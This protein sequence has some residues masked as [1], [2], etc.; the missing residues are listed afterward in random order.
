MQGN[1]E[2]IPL[3]YELGKTLGSATSVDELVQFLTDALVKSLGCDNS[4]VWLL[5]R[6][7]GT[8]TCGSAT[9]PSKKELEGMEARLGEGLIGELMQ[10]QRELWL[11][12]DDDPEKII[13]RFSREFREKTRFMAFV[14]L[15]GREELLGAILLSHRS[16]FREDKRMRNMTFLK[17]LAVD[18]ASAMEDAHNREQL[19]KRIRDLST[20]S[21]VGTE[22]NTSLELDKVLRSVVLNIMGHFIVEKVAILLLDD[23]RERLGPVESRGLPDEISNLDFSCEGELAQILMGTQRPV[24]CYELEDDAVSLEEREKLEELNAFVLLPVLC[25]DEFLGLITVGQKVTGEAYDE[26]DVEFLSTIAKQTGIAAKNCMLF[27]AER[28]AAELSLLLEISKEITSTLDIDRVLHAFVNLSSQVIN[29]DRAAVALLRGENLA[30]SALSGQEK[31]DR[32]AQEVSALEE[33][34]SWMSGQG[35]SIY[36]TSLEGQIQAQNQ[37]TKDRLKEYFEKSQM[38]S[39]LAVPLVDEEGALGVLSME[40]ESQS[41][42]TESNLEVIEI[43][44]NQ[45]TVA[46]RNAELYGKIPL[47]KVIHP[48]V[49]KKR[50]FFKI[51]RRKLGTIIAGATIILALLLLW[52]SELKITCPME[53]WPQRT[54]TIAA[55]VEGILQEV[56][57]RDGHVVQTG[58][59]LA[60]LHNDHISSRLNQVKVWLATSRGNARNLFAANRISQYQTEQDEIKKLEA[61]LTFLETQVQ[62][63]EMASPISGTILTPLLEEK[64]GEYLE[65]GD[66]FC[67]VALLDSM[68]AEI[69]FPAADIHLAEENQEIKLLLSAFPEKTFW[70]TVEKVS[71]SA[72]FGQD[73]NTFLVKGRIDNAD[74]LLKPGMTGHARV[75]CGKRSLAY[76]VFRKPGRLVRELAWRLFGL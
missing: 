59:Q 63:T 23:T 36:V 24:F 39:F 58:Q 19:A 68:R 76:V 28:K 54:Y 52:R 38:K 9:A 10:D 30:L 29:Y 35:Q 17:R 57:V 32:K 7:Q 61:E 25:Q 50:A 65:K 66:F 69:R 26:S 44:S 41:F 15:R 8:V 14:P 22:L 72:G 75:Y 4:S 21:E 27:E 51:P 67:E 5:S 16:R 6:P 74:G 42:L 20:L 53:I 1:K 71:S 11:A 34:L 49:E 62:K 64:V 60:K 31:V 48:I 12:D 56:L 55:E 2:I 43:L 45:L 46:I 33:L 70:G 18:A 47:A 40:S 37:E 3:L 13:P 73:K